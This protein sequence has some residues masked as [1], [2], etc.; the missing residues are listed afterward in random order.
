MQQIRSQIA[1]R[2]EKWEERHKRSEKEKS[3]RRDYEDYGIEE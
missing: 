2:N 1:R 3:L